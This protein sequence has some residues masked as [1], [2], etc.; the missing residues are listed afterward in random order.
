LT[1]HGTEIAAQQFAS[2]GCSLHQIAHARDNRERKQDNEGDQ[3]WVRVTHNATNGKLRQR[4]RIGKEPCHK[5][6]Q[7]DVKQN[8][9]P[10]QTSSTLPPLTGP[11]E[12]T[13]RPLGGGR[14]ARLPNACHALTAP[15]DSIRGKMCPLQYGC[16]I[17]CSEAKSK[18]LNPSTCKSGFTRK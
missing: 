1:D 13:Q 12:P 2:R 17:A 5:R 3:E 7:K 11:D 6:A 4:R 10:Y 9:S 14:A 8:C 15:Y 16:S 18:R